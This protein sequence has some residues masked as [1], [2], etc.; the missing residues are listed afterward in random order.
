M[1]GASATLLGHGAACDA[2]GDVPSGPMGTGTSTLPDHHVGSQPAA[3]ASCP[4]LPRPNVQV[5]PAAF[6]G[7]S[8]CSRDHGAWPREHAAEQRRAKTGCVRGDRGQ[9]QSLWADHSRLLGAACRPRGGG[10]QSGADCRRSQHRRHHCHHRLHRRRRGRQL[11]QPQYDARRCD[12]VDALLWAQ[13]SRCANVA[14]HSTMLLTPGSPSPSSHYHHR[15]PRLP[16]G[17]QLAQ[18]RYDARQCDAVDALLWAQCSRCAD[19]AARRNAEA[20][21][22]P[23]RLMRRALV[24]AARI[25]VFLNTSNLPSLN[26]NCSPRSPG[27]LTRPIPW[28]IYS[29]CPEARQFA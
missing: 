27:E 24:R 12:A 22:M 21:A 17:R 1:P 8:S 19:V 10:F 14:A 15:L 20:R 5:I 13:Y 7:P 4:N 23:K 29:S 9:D 28:P 25:G 6:Y 3:A 18:P 11:A 2:R 26:C 16:H